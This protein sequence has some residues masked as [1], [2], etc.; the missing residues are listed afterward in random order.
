MSLSIGTIQ[1]KPLSGSKT[2]TQRGRA[3]LFL[4]KCRKLLASRLLPWFAR[5]GLLFI[6]RL[7]A[8]G[9]RLRWTASG[10]A[11]KDSVP[12][13][14]LSKNPELLSVTVKNT[15]FEPLRFTLPNPLIFPEHTGIPDAFKRFSTY[16][17]PSL[18]NVEFRE[19]S[20]LSNPRNIALIT[21]HGYVIDHVSV[22]MDK[23]K[24]GFPYNNIVIPKGIHLKGKSLMLSSAMA[25]NNY[26]HWM[27]EC[28]PRLAALQ[29]LGRNLDDFDHILIRNTG[30]PFQDW[31][32]NTL[33][34]PRH[35]IYQNRSGLDLCHCDSLTTTTHPIYHVPSLFVTNW[36]RKTF[37]PLVSQPEGPRRIF[38][39]RKGSRR[40]L[41][42][43]DDIYTSLADIGFVRLNLDQLPLVEQIGIFQNANIIVG[44]HG[45]GLTNL[46]F[47]KPGTRVVEI[48]DST[49]IHCMY[50][51]LAE[52]LDL[53]YRAVIHGD[54][55]TAN[56][57]PST[58]R[59]DP[60]NPCFVRDAVEAS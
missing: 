59:R 26:Y 8:R 16:S 38:I 49:H 42:N 18:T 48:F 24:H 51:V 32:I 25:E 33:G 13:D 37:L 5:S 56:G 1:R 7:L 44:S 60:L 39:S 45:A 6:F 19:C 10:Y 27:F 2:P 47:C 15:I 23:E 43:E 21:K 11:L 4:Q 53:K 57:T 54:L 50:W 20:V 28:L 36:L 35:K 46:A 3:S 29:Q 9:V 31:T 52:R 55:P 58:K 12:Y 40:C 30:L 22:C 14:V 17:D 41:D 34:I